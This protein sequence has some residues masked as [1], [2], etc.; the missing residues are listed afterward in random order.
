VTNGNFTSSVR[1]RSNLPTQ[2]A[3]VLRGIDLGIKN[4]A[5]IAFPDEYVLYPGNSLKQDKHYFTRAEYD[6]EERTARQKNRCGRVGNSPN[7]RYTS[8]TR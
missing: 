1:S 2:Q 3:T 6:T 8:T 7:V 5:T 4:I